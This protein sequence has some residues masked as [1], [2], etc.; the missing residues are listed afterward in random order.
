M[1]HFK[2]AGK[3]SFTILDNGLNVR[4]VDGVFIKKWWRSW[5]HDTR[6]IL[7][8]VCSTTVHTIVIAFNFQAS[9]KGECLEFC[10]NVKGSRIHYLF[11]YEYLLK[12]NVLL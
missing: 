11:I 3:E 2:N 4:A 6:G 7:I 1:E 12:E 8:V 9:Q 10:E 5:I